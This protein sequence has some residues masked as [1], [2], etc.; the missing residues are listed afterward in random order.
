MTMEVTVTRD[1]LRVVTRVAM[2]MN[3]T[4]SL[5]WKV[6]VLSLDR[7]TRGER[8]WHLITIEAMML[9]VAQQDGTVAFRAQVSSNGAELL[10]LAQ[11]HRR[12]VPLTVSALHDSL[13]TRPDDHW[14][15]LSSAAGNGNSGWQRGKEVGLRRD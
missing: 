15:C 12:S 13:W 9:H 8:W 14:L 3:G 10:V 6:E 4:E 7:M 1:E 2:E 5:G 11:S